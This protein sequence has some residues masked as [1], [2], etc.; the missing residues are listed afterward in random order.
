ML[1]DFFF[2]TIYAIVGFLVKVLP[3]TVFG[4]DVN[5]LSEFGANLGVEISQFSFM[6]PVKL[7]IL[8]II[9]I[10]QL[11]LAIALFGLVKWLAQL[12]RGS[13]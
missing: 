9:I 11:E 8:F 5:I 4:L 2:G 3:S 7:G 13:G 10:I 1:F 12:I 6:F